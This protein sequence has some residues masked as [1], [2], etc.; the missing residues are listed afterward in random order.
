[1]NQKPNELDT[2]LKNL[3]LDFA[4][5]SIFLHDSEG[6]FIYV[7]EAAYKTRGYTENELMNINLHKLDAPE[8]SKMIEKRVKEIMEHGESTFESEHFH[9]DGS[10]I[11]VEIHVRIIESEGKKLFLSIARDISERKKSEKAIEE[12]QIHL[13]KTVKKRTQ[14]LTQANK[15]L[16]NEIN[17]R[18]KA[19]TRIKNGKKELKAILDS[20]NESIF[21][22]SE[23]GIILEVNE[24]TANRFGIKKADMMGKHIKNFIQPEVFKSRWKYLEKALKTKKPIE[25][26]DERE[27]KFFIHAIYPIYEEGKVKKLAIFSKDITQKKKMEKSSKET[28]NKLEA[29]LKAIP[30]L[31][32]EIDGEGRFYNYYAPKSEDLFVKPDAFMGKKVSEI[33][34]KEVAD[35]IL[36][37]INIASKKGIHK[38]TTYSLDFPQGKKWFELSISKNVKYNHENDLYVALAR[39]ITKLKEKEQ[40]LIYALNY[41]RSLLEVNLD[42]LVTIGVDGKINDVNDAVELVTG[43]TR[44]QVIGTDFSDYFTSP[45]RARAGYEEVF[46][47][48]FVKD[49]S[50]E[51]R[52]KN[53]QVTPVIYNASVYRDDEGDV[54]GVF[55]AARD[56]TEIKRAHDEVIASERRLNS[57]IDGSPIPQFVINKDHKIIYWND[58]LEE[59]SGIRAKE[60]IGKEEQWRVFYNEKRPCLVDL[61]VDE[62]QAE[63]PKWY[64]GKASKSKFIKDAYEATDFFPTISED[65]KWLYFTAAP[66]KD[67]GNKIIGAVETLEDI[68]EMKKAEIALQTSEEKYRNIVETAL[69]GIWII[70]EKANTIYVNQSMANILGYSINE[71]MGRSLFDFMDEEG[72]IDASDKMEKR[73]KGIKEVHD[74]R[75]L[76]KDGSE[77]WTMISTNPLFDKNGDFIGALGMLSDITHRKQMEAQ[78]KDSLEEKK[79]L[80]KEIH[81]RVKNNLMIISSLLNLQSGYINDEESKEIF[82]E[83]ENRARSMA[84]IH[85]RLYESTDLK[86]ID[87][88]E[89]IQTL[90]YELF[91]TYSDGSGRVNLKINVE[92]IGMDINTA[93]PLSLV[94]NELVTN[95]LKYAFPEGRTGDIEIDF[96]STDNAYKLIVNDTGVGLPKDL[97]Y[98]KTDS[99]GLQLV[100]NLTDQ[101]NGEIKLDRTR[102]TTF[103]ITFPKPRKL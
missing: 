20:S 79:M 57:I 16:Q 30:D 64:L 39:D 96:Y 29:T 63:I 28:R 15:K 71:M 5:D 87:F 14:E 83:S 38:G 25:F 43:Y 32:F 4:S 24:A 42:P 40:E 67:F 73:R 19:E 101:I 59:I 53:G 102:G 51:I 61:L 91:D 17:E 69:E 95:S 94:I 2:R 72:K 13:E 65:G 74:F 100:T 10:I 45:E 82:K 3:M 88:G 76:H 44:D 77:V 12:V 22:V 90:V 6:N 46:K 47:H 68:T 58:A 78:I 8:Y 21:L 66:I 80:L 103:N 75:F 81:H 54:L 52:H 98:T 55:A 1:M 99:L 93:I 60:I 85:E 36:N 70:D 49:Y 56:I 84:L 48:G 37:A 33:L 41:N 26:E 31:M 92:D 34:P 89:Y 97:D 23:S 9:K 86:N 7:N 27:G 11:P 50:L 62:L 18:K 35:K